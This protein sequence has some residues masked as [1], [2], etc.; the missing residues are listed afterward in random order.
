MYSGISQF[1]KDLVPFCLVVDG[2][3]WGVLWNVLENTYLSLLLNLTVLLKRTMVYKWRK[4]YVVCRKGLNF[5]IYYAVLF[6]I[7]L[8]LCLQIEL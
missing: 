1:Y 6:E 5:R 2:I 7:K 4:K 3:F 8:L